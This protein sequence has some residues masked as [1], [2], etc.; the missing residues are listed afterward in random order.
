MRFCASSV[1][2]SAA[3]D[4]YQLFL[5]PEEI[6]DSDGDPLEAKGSYLIVQKQFEYPD[7]GRSYI[8]THD[9]HY[10]GHFRLTLTELSATRLVFELARKTNNQVHISYSLN[11]SEFEEVRRIAEVVFGVREPDPKDDVDVL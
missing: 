6:D 5:G 9:E 1:S 8:E 2:G 11:A 3:G 7:Q 4:Y 10:V